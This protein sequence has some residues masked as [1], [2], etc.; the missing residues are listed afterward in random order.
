MN[1]KGVAIFTV[2]ISCGLIW[3]VASGNLAYLYALHLESK[4]APANPQTKL[5][6]EN[7]LSLY[8][9][10][11]I[12]PAESMWGENY[13]LQ[14]NEKMIQYRILWSAP[15]DVVYDKQN[16]IVNIYTSYE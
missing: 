5:E 2:A 15:L 7:Y 16:N 9:T 10:R 12:E 6:L 1:K 4:W 11:E 14:D 3:F 8:S 13:V